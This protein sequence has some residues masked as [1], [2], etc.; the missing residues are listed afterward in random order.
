MN[1]IKMRFDALVLAM[2]LVEKYQYMQECADT[3]HRIYFWNAQ[4]S[5][6]LLFLVSKWHC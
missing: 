5:N 6:F 1:I 3:K 4:F 2:I